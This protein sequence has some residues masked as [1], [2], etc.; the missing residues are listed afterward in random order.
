MME[1]AMGVGGEME[2]VRLAVAYKHKMRVCCLHHVGKGIQCMG[3]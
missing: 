3:A 1:T 2:K